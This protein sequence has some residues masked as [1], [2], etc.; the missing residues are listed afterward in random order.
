MA[1]PTSQDRGEEGGAERGGA[2]ERGRALGAEDVGLADLGA[3]DLGG[4]GAESTVVRRRARCGSQDAGAAGGAVGVQAHLVVLLD[5]LV[6]RL[7]LLR[8]L[9]LGGREL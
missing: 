1:A 9:R 4:L 2:V 7:F 6:D 3:R 8:E 5:L